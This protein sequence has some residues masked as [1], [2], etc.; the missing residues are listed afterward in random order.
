MYALN[1]DAAKAAD[2]TGN[3]I[4]ERGKYKGR[5]TRAQHIVAERTGTQGIDF[6]FE[7]ES[8]QKARFSIY[9]LKADGT[10]IYGF[11]QLMAIMTVLS[12]KKVADPVNMPAKVYDYDA[13]QEVTKTIPQFQ[14][15]LNKPIGLLFTME[16]YKESKWRPNLAG[17][18]AAGTELTASEILDRKTTPTTLPKMVERLRDKPYQGVPSGTNSATHDS[19]AAQAPAGFDD[20]D[21]PF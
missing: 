6:D 12:L 21:I 7:S 17:I 3:R 2:S 19:M 16:E 14:E 13:G 1:P 20:S 9:T 8:G 5:F 11:K 4:T 18:F 15:L 10:Q